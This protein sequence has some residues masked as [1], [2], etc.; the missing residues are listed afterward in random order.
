VSHGDLFGGDAFDDTLVGRGRDLLRIREFLADANRGGALLLSGEAGVGKTVLLDALADAAT[1]AGTRVL[2]AAG[3]EFE[4]DVSYSGLNQLL[5]PIHESFRD[6][7]ETHRDALRVALGF[8]SGPPVQRLL[9]SNATM[10]L[11]RRATAESPLLLIVDDIPWIDPASAAVLGFVAR[12]LPGSQVSFLAASR[13]GSYRSSESG[14]LP[15][16]ELPPLDEES[17]TVLVDTRFPGLA[18]GVRRRLL[19]AAQGNPLALLELPTALK[20]TQRSSLEHLPAVLPLSQRLQALFVSRVASLP[21]PTHRLLLLATLDGSGDLG[22]LQAA[23]QQANFHTDLDALGPAERDQL[24]QIDTSAR[25]LTFRHPL[26]RSAVMEIST[27]SERLSAH[28]ALAQAL[29][30][31]PERRAWHLGEASLQPDESVAEM[32]EEAAHQ[33]LRRGDAIGAVTALTRA[34]ELSPLGIDRGRRLAEAAYIGADATGALDNAWELLAGARRADPD[35]SGSLHSTAAAVHLTL[36]DQGDIETAHRLLTGAIK[37]GTHRYDARDDA[38]IDALHLLLLLCFFGGRPELWEPFNAAVARLLP[39]AP[40]LLS[41]AGKLFSDPVRQGAGALAQLESILAGARDE[42]DPARIVR[43]GTASLY[44]DRLGDVREPSWRVVRQGR[45]GG[46]VRRQLG[47]LMHLCLDDYLTGKWEEAS[48]LADEGLTLCEDVGYTFFSWYFLY[49]KAMIGAARGDSGTSDVLNERI[50]RWAKPRGVRTAVHYAHH[51]RALTALGS[52]DFESAYQHASDISPAGILAAYVPHALWS[53]MD[54]VEA[55][56]R[57]NRHAEAAAHVRA[58]TEANIAA[59]SPRLALL[60]GGSAAMCATDDDESVRLFEKTLS[61]PHV[62]RWPFDLARVQLAYG[63]RLRR[64]RATVSSRGPLGAAL[65]AF[66]ELGAKPWA[67]RATKE[68]RAAGWS[69]P[70]AGDH[71]PQVLTPQEREIATLAASGLTNKQI[72]AQLFLSHR[73]VGAHLY[74]IFPKLGITSRAALSS[75]L[76]ALEQDPPRSAPR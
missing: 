20:G 53:V 64:A 63:E 12:R 10:L 45:D 40:V 65:E 69:A 46:P 23:T 75:A 17:A 30:D 73:T 62:D 14:D 2:R 51:C 58:M 43:M 52:G 11:L 3:V 31:Q 21:H 72:A 56:V 15:E 6:L 57:T 4:A 39:E 55:A 35:L 71:P 42:T 37:A 49:S 25:R 66:E 41:V 76:A 68:L 7:D 29:L 50:I 28:R 59:L 32:L 60:A 13:S 44:A 36:N 22:V 1:A 8:G 54:L 16:Y 74:Q 18:G 26:I 24:V 67:E 61:L 47:A 70:G 9:V 19:A 38:L 27:S 34:A 33:I 5:F 48:E